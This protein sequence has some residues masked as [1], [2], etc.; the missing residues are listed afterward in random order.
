M[1]SAP[2]TFQ[3]IFLSLSLRG[4]ELRC[5]DG[6]GGLNMGKER[7]KIVQTPYPLL[8]EER[9]KKKEEAEYTSQWKFRVLYFSN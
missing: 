9:R 6:V 3:L 7:S 4:E 2:A 8:Y 5:V 1:P